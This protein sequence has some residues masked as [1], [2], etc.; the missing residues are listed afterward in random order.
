[1]NDVRVASYLNSGGQ[2]KP[3]LRQWGHTNRT[4]TTGSEF[5]WKGKLSRWG[6]VSV[7]DAQGS[8]YLGSGNL[9]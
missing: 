4:R 7:H 1:M 8:L 5:K 9:T 6:S 3:R 2:G